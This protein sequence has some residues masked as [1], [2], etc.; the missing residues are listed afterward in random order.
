MKAPTFV[1]AV[2]WSLIATSAFA[3]AVS[4]PELD[5][6]SLTTGLALLGGGLLLLGAPRRR[7]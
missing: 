7:K 3:E 5:P 1:T 4:V 2:L 6:G